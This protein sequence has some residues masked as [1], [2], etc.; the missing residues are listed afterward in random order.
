MKIV[1]R[2]LTKMNDHDDTDVQAHFF[3]GPVWDDPDEPEPEATGTSSGHEH[4]DEDDVEGHASG[5]G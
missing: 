1:L 2:E 4:D 5:F 3:A